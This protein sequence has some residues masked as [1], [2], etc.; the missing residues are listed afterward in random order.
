M[1]P[2]AYRDLNDIFAYIAMEKLFPENAKKQTDR[3]REKLKTLE[4]FPQSHQERR[5]GQ[6]AK[7]GYRQLLI[8]NYIVI[9]RIDETNRIV[10]II[11][12]Q[13]QGRNI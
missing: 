8:D 6:Y 11:T 13:Y 5:D 10:Q 7:M 3:I 12:I 1:S 4:T 2:R 9:F